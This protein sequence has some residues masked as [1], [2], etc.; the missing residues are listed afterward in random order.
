MNNSM[1]TLRT[2]LLVL[3]CSLLLASVS[4]AQQIYSGN[5]DHS[6]MKDEANQLLAKFRNQ[7]PN[8][9]F[10]HYF[11]KQAIMSVL[12]QPG[13]VGL[14]FYNAVAKDGRKTLVIVGVDGNGNDIASGE[15]EER[16]FPCPPF[17]DPDT[18]AIH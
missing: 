13:V 2:V 17:C 3:A 10:A 12:S 6:I 15:I 7:N 11:G 8:D 1:N 16:G 9:I 4:N 18:N 5:E 14:R